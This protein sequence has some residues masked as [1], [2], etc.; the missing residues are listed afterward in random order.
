MTAE[1]N[2]KGSILGEIFKEQ[3]FK[4]IQGNRCP[5]GTYDVADG[6]VN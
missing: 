2:D 4:W 6:H 1:K 5:N 3:I